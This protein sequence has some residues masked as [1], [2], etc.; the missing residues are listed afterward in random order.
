MNVSDH[1]Y[2]VAGGT[3]PHNNPSYIRREADQV[4]L[5]S[6][7]ANEFC[8]VLTE[9]QMG[10][11]SLAERTINELSK[12]GFT[13]V[14]LDI[15]F[16]GSTYKSAD[17]WYNS[18]LLPIA[19]ELEIEDEFDQWRE[20]YDFLG[21][22]AKLS[23]FW[24]KVVLPNT[25]GRI[26]IF[27]DEIDSILA[28][29]ENG[30]NSDD[31][32][33]SLRGLYNARASNQNL[34]RINFCMLGVTLRQDLIPDS[35]RTPFNIGRAVRL[36][37][38]DLNSTSPFL[39]GLDFILNAEEVL[40]R[41]FY[42][43]SG[44]PYLTQKL[45]LSLSRS[46][47]QGNIIY[48]PE[49]VDAL[50]EGEFFNKDAVYSDMKIG[51]VRDQLTKNKEWSV[52][53]LSC[54]RKILNQEIVQIDK[55]KREQG[56]L[57]LS[58]LVRADGNQLL[59]N[60]RIYKR[61]FNEEW[62]LET[63]KTLDRPYTKDVER[64]LNNFK[65]HDTLLQGVVLGEALEWRESRVDLSPEESEF[66]ELSRVEFEK[67]EERERQL[68][69]LRWALL[70]ISILF[71]LSAVFGSLSWIQFKDLENKSQEVAIQAKIYLESEMKR[72][73]DQKLSVDKSLN[74][75]QDA[76]LPEIVSDAKTAKISLDH[77]IQKIKRRLDSLKMENKQN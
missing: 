62:V 3:L 68:K 26:F 76:R 8:Y 69:K 30:I 51:T 75:Y 29:R 41:I 1:R 6:L 27:V 36:K 42:W 16:A 9:R 7:L 11:S 44:Q 67:G 18:F 74:L 60:N 57:S 38:F 37:N 17:Q 56:Y 59:V 20:R 45:C 50:V 35:S 28:L 49:K 61:I 46:V 13:C 66:I 15:S 58:G 34:V 71:I 63:L 48:S 32:F 14:Y 10:K 5:D 21:P 77:Q 73:S 24:E 55:N 39:K 70:G 31:F 47:T 19:E 25:N 72:L 53:M 40:E 64:W 22:V 4:L 52:K 12:R 2:F 65:S 23:Y 33:A 54:Y 43:T